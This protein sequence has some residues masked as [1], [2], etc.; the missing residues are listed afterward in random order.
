M[1]YVDLVVDNKSDQTDT[2]YT[3]GCRQDD[4]KIGAKVYVHFGRSKELREAYVFGVKDEPETEFKKLKYIEE[5]DPDISLTEEIVR[6]CRWMKRRYLCRYIDA[7][8]QF[9]PVGAPL[10]S[11]K[12]RKPYKDAEGE[13][14]PVDKLTEEQQ[15]ALAEMTKKQGH[16]IFLLQ[17]VT[18]SGKTELYMRMIEQCL[19]NG[20]KAVM[21]VPEISLTKQI[22]DRFIGR[23]GSERIAVLHSKLSKGQ[24]YDEWMRIRKGQVDIVIGARSGVFAPME[25][26]G[27]FIMD[28]EHEASYKSET[29]PKYD[30]VEVVVKRAMDMD[31]KVVL[32][33]ATPNITSYHRSLEGLYKRIVLKKRY[34]N[35]KLPDVEIVDMRKELKSGNSSVFSNRLYQ[36]MKDNLDT[37]KQVIL[38]MNRRGYS[39]FVS[40]RECGHVMTCPDCGISL[41]YHKEMGRGV[42][43]YCGHTEIIPDKCPECGSRYIRFFGTGTEKIDEEVSR[44][45]PEYETARLDLDSMRKKGSLEKILKDFGRG[46]TS[47]LTGTQVVAK[48]LDFRN[49][50]L[51]GIVAADI[52]LNIPDY[53]SAERTFQ[54]ITQA[55]GRA[56]R[57]E[58]KGLVVIQTYTPENYVI[59]A[60]AAQDYETFYRQEIE[61]RRLRGYP[62]FSDFIQV[63]VGSP[64][65]AVAEN[66]AEEWE[67]QLRRSLGRDEKN[68][69]PHSQMISLAKEG[70]KQCILIKCPKGKRQVYFEILMELKNTIKGDRRKYNVAVDVNPYSMWRS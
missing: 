22:I 67:R 46:K 1:K 8:A 9:T 49:V 42:C 13:Q 36:A 10:K 26:I 3:Y 35:V 25:N 4:I 44:L 32:G 69:L 27:V 61:F 40:C 54:L 63:I 16:E 50:G 19:E 65:S 17:G 41:T 11:G 18:G 20:R 7:A 14:Q 62:P 38:F 21:L 70:Y 31:A 28:E 57:G 2:L 68:V 6:T 5:I 39:T 29:T 15:M 24:R 47:I 51:V 33:S 45:F 23:F 37:G 66:V 53:R 60:A 30:T 59:K 55:A 43:H 12:T 64:D 58:E 48:G 52:S 56:G 34:N